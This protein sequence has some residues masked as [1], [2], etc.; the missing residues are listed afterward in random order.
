MEKLRVELLVA[1]LEIDEAGNLHMYRL[2]QMA[3][4]T[5][6]KKMRVQIDTGMFDGREKQSAG[7]Y[8]W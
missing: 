4:A 6:H 3:E 7:F 8:G 5:S 1:W 2:R